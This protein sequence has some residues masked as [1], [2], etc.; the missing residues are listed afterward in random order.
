MIIYFNYIK[1]SS[2]VNI[3]P[4]LLYLRLSYNQLK[5]TIMKECFDAY[6]N[7]LYNQISNKTFKTCLF[8]I[9]VRTIKS[10]MGDREIYLQQW[11][12]AFIATKATTKYPIYSF[13]PECLLKIV[14]R[15]NLNWDLLYLLCMI[16][17]VR[18]Y[19]ISLFVLHPSLTSFFIPL[20]LHKV[21]A[22]LT[23][24]VTQY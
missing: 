19:H 4:K 24:R 18:K 11:A 1:S 7:C 16:I 8:L 12:H 23:I 5:E 20:Y 22:L 10:R 2:C 9:Y 14:I 13:F 17:K 15:S 6:E 21:I 3:S